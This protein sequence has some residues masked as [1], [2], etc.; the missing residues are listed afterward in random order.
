[1][2]IQFDQPVDNVS[3][4]LMGQKTAEA[5]LTRLHETAQSL[6][7]GGYMP[8]EVLL[9]GAI[10]GVATVH[11]T[12]PMNLLGLRIQFESASACEEWMIHAAQCEG[13]ITGQHNDGL[14]LTGAQVI[15]VFGW[16]KDAEHVNS[17]RVTTIETDGVAKQTTITCKADGSFISLDSGLAAET[18][19]TMARDVIAKASGDGHT[20]H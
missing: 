9:I 20:L 14:K 1:M 5:V 8:I 6:S 15:T 7:V 17:A 2:N 11:R 12:M 18:A 16:T 13:C 3:A 4:H 10:D 19:E